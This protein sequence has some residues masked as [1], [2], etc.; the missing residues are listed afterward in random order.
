[1]QHNERVHV[2]CVHVYVCVLDLWGRNW[3]FASTALVVVFMTMYLTGYSNY[4]TGFHEPLLLP[5]TVDVTPV[6]LVAK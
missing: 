3:M 2:V 1:M 6:N 5:Y 4:L